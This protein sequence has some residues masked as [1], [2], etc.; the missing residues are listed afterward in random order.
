MVTAVQMLA[1]IAI[2]AFAGHALAGPP[3]SAAPPAA[4]AVAK[5]SP[6]T[7]VQPVFNAPGVAPRH[8]LWL[9]VN[10]RWRAVPA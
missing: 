5:P 4:V 8:I 3:A 7:G 9:F 10:G 6:V 2:T 1:I